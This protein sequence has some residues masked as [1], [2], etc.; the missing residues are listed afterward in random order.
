M[1]G[2]SQ[3]GVKIGRRRS[4]QF[5]SKLS[6][7]LGRNGET[8]PGVCKGSKSDKLNAGKR[9]RSTPMTTPFLACART[10]Q[11]GINGPSLHSQE[12]LPSSIHK[13]RGAHKWGASSMPTEQPA[14][15]FC[16][17][18]RGSC[19]CAKQGAAAEHN[20]DANDHDR[21]PSRPRGRL[22]E[23]RHSEERRKDWRERAKHRGA[24]P[25]SL[26]TASPNKNSLM[27][28]G[29]TRLSDYV[30]WPKADRWQSTEYIRASISAANTN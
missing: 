20:S 13:M 30:S 7:M 24:R 9:V 12:N 8:T 10:S 5:V 22:S 19:R 25:P 2:T 16:N 14:A 17:M 4:L 11:M 3:E 23:Q 28:A 29:M 15:L 27:I 6:L 1:S 21:R 18:S 26:R